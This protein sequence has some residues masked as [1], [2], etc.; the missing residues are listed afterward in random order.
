MWRNLRTRHLL[1]TRFL[2]AWCG[3]WKRWR[4][5]RSTWKGEEVALIKGMS[6]PLGGSRHERRQHA[7]LPDLVEGEVVEVPQTAVRLICPKVQ[8]ISQASSEEE[9]VQRLMLGR[10]G[11]AI[12]RGDQRGGDPGLPGQ[13]VRRVGNEPAGLRGV[14]AGSDQRPSGYAGSS[15]PRW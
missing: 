10:E 8:L 14:A 6:Y 7:G 5:S 11:Q 9:L 15:T 4:R 12:G 1:T 3:A 13:L 2:E